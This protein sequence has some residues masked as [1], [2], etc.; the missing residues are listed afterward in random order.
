M[1]CGLYVKPD[2]DAMNRTNKADVID[3]IANIIGIK[4]VTHMNMDAKLSDLGIDSLM[5]M[6]IVQMLERNYEIVL[7]MK[8]IK[9]VCSRF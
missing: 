5:G 8:D 9:T 3:I 1:L 4:D 2:S 6:E 7:S